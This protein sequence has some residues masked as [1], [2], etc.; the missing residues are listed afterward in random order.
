MFDFAGSYR[1]EA[2][3]HVGIGHREA[4]FVDG[5]L[6]DQVDDAFQPLFCI[7]R[8]VR[9]LLHQL[10]EHL[11]CQLVQDASYLAEQLL[12]DRKTVTFQHKSRRWFQE[13]AKMHLKGERR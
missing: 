1:Y 13:Q 10:V 11:G 2:P 12:N 4:G 6:E 8:Q 5:L 9:H 7:Y 3:A